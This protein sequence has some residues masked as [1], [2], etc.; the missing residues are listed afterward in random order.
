MTGNIVFWL[1]VAVLLFWSL[2][3]YNRLVRLRAQKGGRGSA[4]PLHI[5]FGTR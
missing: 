4:F 1:A 2:G 5:G 3:A